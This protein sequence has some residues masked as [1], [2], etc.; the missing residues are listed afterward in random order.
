VKRKEVEAKE[1]GGRRRK[2]DRDKPGGRKKDLMRNEHGED[3]DDGKGIVQWIEQSVRPEV[4]AWRGRKESGR[5][6]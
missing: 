5:Q 2:G 3:K 6:E 1:D 4:D